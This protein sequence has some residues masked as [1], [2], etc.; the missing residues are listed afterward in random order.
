MNARVLTMIGLLTGAVGIAMLWASGVVFPFY[1]PPGILILSAG[2]IF[3][4]L[5]KWRWA[6]LIGTALGLFIIIGFLL[7]PTG[8]P[9]LTG[10]Y[11]IATSIGTV[12]QLAG[13]LVATI[14]GVA[15]VAPARRVTG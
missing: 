11:G 14:A 4:A 3:I 9:N 2:T 12:I 1:P 15:A 5:V 6:P 8:I 7:S 10:D 13:V